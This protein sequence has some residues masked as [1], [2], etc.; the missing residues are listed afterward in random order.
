VPGV[1]VA[2][3]MARR[4]IIAALVAARWCPVA[5]ITRILTLAEIVA[6]GAGLV[7]PAL[8]VLPLVKSAHTRLEGTRARSL[9]AAGCMFAMAIIR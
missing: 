9:R 5:A 7:I 1:F 6:F 3:E 8:V 4:A 2:L